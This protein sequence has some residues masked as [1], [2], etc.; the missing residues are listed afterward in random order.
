MKNK[1]EEESPLRR[2]LRRKFNLKI[3]SDPEPP[4][5]LLFYPD[6]L[7]AEQLAA[8]STLSHFC[9]VPSHGPDLDEP[10]ARTLLDPEVGTA[11]N[12]PL[13]NFSTG[14]V[15]G[16]ALQPSFAPYMHQ[17]AT[18]PVP[19]SASVNPHAPLTPARALPSHLSKRS[20][21]TVGPISDQTPSPLHTLPAD[22]R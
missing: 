9:Q 1:V 18:S 15:S 16:P 13:A 6:E 10:S 19:C 22:E 12:P 8:L 5:L 20:P 4:S 2:K 7:R 14:L 3:E 21:T 11:C 17:R